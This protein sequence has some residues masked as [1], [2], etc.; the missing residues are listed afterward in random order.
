M[1]LGVRATYTRCVGHSKRRATISAD[2]FA[3]VQFTGWRLRELPHLIQY[4]GAGT[5]EP[6]QVVPAVG[7]RET[8]RNPTIAAAEIDIDGARHCL[9]GQ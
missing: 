9:S 1:H 8:V 2:S 3:H 5:I 6:H 4:L 7:N